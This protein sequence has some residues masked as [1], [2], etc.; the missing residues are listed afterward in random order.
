V[1]E[2]RLKKNGDR[3]EIE[4]GGGVTIDQSVLCCILKI[5]S[6]TGPFTYLLDEFEASVNACD[7]DTGFSISYG[8]SAEEEGGNREVSCC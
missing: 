5:L 8:I 2:L 7:P 3:V 4:S 6:L 1:I